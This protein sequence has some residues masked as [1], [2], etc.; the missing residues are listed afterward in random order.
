MYMY[1]GTDTNTDINIGAILGKTLVICPLHG[2][3]HL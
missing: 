2:L 1:V 3:S